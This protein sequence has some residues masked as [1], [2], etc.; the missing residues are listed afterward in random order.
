MSDRSSVSITPLGVR[1][2]ALFVVIALLLSLVPLLAPAPAYAATTYSITGRGYGHGVG[3]SQFGAKGFAEHGYTYD[4]ILAHYYSGTTLG[5]VAP[6]TVTVAL[7]DTKDVRSSWSLRS[8]EVGGRLV[9]NGE[10]APA[11]AIYTFKPSGSGIAAY[12]GATLWKVFSAPV[13]VVRAT[14]FVGAGRYE[15]NNAAI[16]YSGTWV[17]N[18]ASAAYSGGTYAYS[19]TTGARASLTFSGTSIGIVG[20]KGPYYGQ[21]KVSVDGGTPVLVETYQPELA[22]QQTL[23]EVRDLQP[24]VHS[25]TV[26]VTGTKNASSSSAVIVLDAMDV[27]AEASLAS[28]S[29]AATGPLLIQVVDTSGPFNR[30]YVRYRGAMNLALSGSG[31][32]LTNTVALEDYLYGVVPRESPSSWHAEALKSQAVAARSYAYTET[33]TLYCTTYSQV[34]GGHSITDVTRASVTL[35]EASATNAAVDATRNQVVKSGSTVARTYFY[36]SSGG[37]TANSEDVFYS[38]LPYCRAVPDPYEASAAPATGWPWATSWGDPIVYDGSALA[39]KLGYS[40]AV[41]SLTCTTAKSGHVQTVAMRLASGA[42]VSMTGDRFRSK[43]GLRSTVFQVNGPV[44]DV[45]RV[46]D[47]SS[48]V[49]Y[50]GTWPSATSSAFSGGTYRYSLKAGSTAT[51]SATTSNIAIV[52]SYGPA[53]GKAEVWIDGVRAGTIDAYAPAYA[54]DKVLF[55]LTGYATKTHTIQVRVLGTKNPASTGVTFILDAY[56]FTGAPVD[57]RPAPP[58]ETGRVEDNNA[59]VTYPVGGWY[60]VSSSAFSGGTYRYS[61]KAGSAAQLTGTTASVGIVG[62]YGPGYGKAEV[63]IDGVSAGVIDAYAPSYAHNQV[64]FSKAVSAGTHTVVLKALGTKNASSTG[65]VFVFDAVDFSG[66]PVDL[67]PGETLETGRIEDSSARV[68]YTA[69]SWYAVSSPAFSGGT[70]RYTTK[71]NVIAQVSIA[72]DSVGIVGSYG[73]NYGKAEVLIDGVSAGVIDAYSASYAHNRVLFSKAV[74]PGAHTVVLKALGTKNDASTASTFIF[75]AFDFSGAPV[76]PSSGITG[77]IEDDSDK[78][79]YAGTWISGVSTAF[80]G[81][82]YRYASWSTSKVGVTADARSVAIVGSYGPAY[83]KAEVFIDGVSAGVIDAYAPAA[84]HNRVLFVKTGLT[85]GE[86]TIELRV[87]GTKNS[88]STGAAFIFDAFDFSASSTDPA[89]AGVTSIAPAAA[90]ATTAP[91]SADTTPTVPA[92]EAT[93]TVGEDG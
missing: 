21:M 53:Y 86:H 49:A 48:R 54:H 50:A 42:N 93:V 20:N 69:S 22:L 11:D 8:G 10:M 43:L 70:Y 71:S 13:Q 92:I 64:L 27:D 24:G 61:N 52:G 36:S 79:T 1:A 28:V 78:L 33:G 30:Q 6:S 16:M 34:Y 73:P 35:Y 7:E 91:G 4:R 29:L 51:L 19:Y 72:A 65:T 76:D 17:K 15:D 77:R 60:A 37:Y 75:D 82:T 66:A 87:L 2:V 44:L 39:A 14:D 26:E 74:A 46:E 45:G 32:T 18:Q 58:L 80:S 89:P 47:S 88:A 41:V 12:N 57:A 63:W 90:P 83:G 38:A 5:T 85:A 56:D 67:R 59:R 31:V 84:A 25:V 68:S 9:V 23:Y 55:S 81:G 3:L 62:S 40:S